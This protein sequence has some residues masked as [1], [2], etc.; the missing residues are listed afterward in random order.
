MKPKILSHLVVLFCLSA[1][2]VRSSNPGLACTAITCTTSNGISVMSNQN[3]DTA[4][5]ASVDSMSIHLSTGQS[6]S[7][8]VDSITCNGVKINFST[9][10]IG[11]N[12][13]SITL[14]VLGKPG[15]YKIS[16]KV[17]SVYFH[18]LMFT[19]VSDPVGFPKRTAN[20]KD[21]VVFP[22][23]TQQG[24]TVL[25][26]G[27]GLKSIRIVSSLGKEL[28]NIQI[29]ED[30]PLELPLRDYPQGFYFIYATTLSDKVVV[31]KITVL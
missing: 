8:Y 21:L 5:V 31:K 18:T 9:V 16:A 12:S 14:K 22:N 7:I 6:C 20:T 27:D 19:L 4:Y 17:S 25:P 11:F 29:K 23:P 2:G 26:G 28:E 15:N 13:Q 30:K 3:T 10:Q 1:F 24:I